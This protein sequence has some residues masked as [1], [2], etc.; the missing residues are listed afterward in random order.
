MWAGKRTNQECN[1][2]N[3]YIMLLSRCCCLVV[4]SR[5]TL[6]NP[7]DCSTPG[8]PVHHQLPS[9]LKLMSIE[10]VM[11]SNT[12]ILCCPLLLLPSIFLSIRVRSNKSTLHIR[13]QIIARLKKILSKRTGRSI[14]RNKQKLFW[15]VSNY[16]TSL[17]STSSL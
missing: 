17:I 14:W 4:Q 12:L 11:P 13:W 2:Y 1:C 15:Y 5:P 3:W 10:S 8:L 16:K 9:L 7:M 6:C